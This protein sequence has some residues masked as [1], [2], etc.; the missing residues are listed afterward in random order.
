[1][2]ARGSG[3]PELQ[4]S[5]EAERRQQDLTA[6]S[7]HGTQGAALSAAA[8]DEERRANVWTR[9]IPMVPR[10]ARAPPATAPATAVKK[11][12]LPADHEYF[13]K[14]VLQATVKITLTG[15]G[16]PA[17]RNEDVLTGLAGQGIAIED[18][19]T[20]WKGSNMRYLNV[21]FNTI[22]AAKRAIQVR[23]F[24]IGE[25]TVTIQGQEAATEVK[26]LWAPSWIHDR[27]IAGCF[28]EYGPL[29]SYRQETTRIGDHKTSTGTKYLLI[30]TTPE[31][32]E[33]IPHVIEVAGPVNARLLVHVRGRPPLCLSCFGAGH[34][35][36]NCPETGRGPA[37][38]DNDDL[39]D[40]ETD[41]DTDEE[42]EED[43]ESANTSTNATSHHDGTQGADHQSPPP[44]SPPPPKD[45]TPTDDHHEGTQ[46]ATHHTTPPPLPPKNNDHHDGTQ[47]AVDTSP[48]PQ[49]P[50]TDTPADEDTQ[51]VRES[52]RSLESTDEPATPK[53]LMIPLDMTDEELTAALTPTPPLVMD[54]EHPPWTETPSPAL[55]PNPP[56]P[57]T[58]EI[59]LPKYA[60]PGPERA[61]SGSRSRQTTD[62]TPYARPAEDRRPRRDSDRF[63]QTSTYQEAASKAEIS[64]TRFLNGKEKKATKNQDNANDAASRHDDRHDRPWNTPDWPPTEG[65]SKTTQQHKDELPPKETTRS[66]ED[67]KRDDSLDRFLTKKD[68]KAKNTAKDEALKKGLKVP[69]TTRPGQVP[70]EQ[71]RPWN[72]SDWPAEENNLTKRI[73]EEEKNEVWRIYEL[74]N[75]QKMRKS[76]PE[77]Y[78]SLLE[79]HRSYEEKFNKESKAAQDDYIRIRKETRLKE[80]RN[81][82]KMGKPVPPECLASV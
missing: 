46:D 55:Q 60:K 22:D 31:S 11:V 71:D 56:S 52:P 48:S 80:M 9:K 74:H 33:A 21:T 42:G 15:E 10:P 18:V 62:Q 49:L 16:W 78:K 12:T 26:V 3:L 58:S 82:I 73:E 1:M 37:P 6:Q 4:A 25:A 67:N 24:K 43:M 5:L 77:Q 44:T 30:K 35:E 36:R 70:P 38:K 7:H 29:L 64:L 2:S 51:A 32:R 75:L 27:F 66:T 72:K 19:H 8:Q 50:E 13:K 34:K 47:G 17:L 45:D 14:D 59:F 68:E 20:F 79:N 53:T 61:R 65:R 57:T 76:Y 40:D 63:R 81:D 69:T 28:E 23:Q 41:Q 39:K 54:V